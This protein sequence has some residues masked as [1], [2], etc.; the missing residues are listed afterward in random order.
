MTQKP[1]NGSLRSI[2]GK[3]CIFYDGHWIRHYPLPED[4]LAN[5]KH[6]IDSLTRR[7][8]HHTEA[9]I[10][11]PGYRLDEARAAYEQEKVSS[12]KRVNGAMLAGALFNRATDIFTAIVDLE[13]KGVAIGHDNPLMIECEN[14]FREAL[15]LGKQVKHY[16]GEEGIDEL[17]GEPLKA[18]TQPLSQLFESRYRKI[19]QTMEDIDRVTDKLISTFS[20]IEM[21]KSVVPLVINYASASKLQI[22]TMKSDSAFFQVWPAFIAAREALEQFTPDY[23]PDFSDEI[24]RRVERGVKLITIGAALITYLSEARVP[25]PKSTQQFL[26][27]SDAF[28]KSWRRE[29]PPIKAVNET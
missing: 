3:E 18:F 6:L 26:D 7:T 11:T 24:S 17:W 21:F 13:D 8:F 22:E 14:C 5:R 25:M 19:A 9:G 16:S 27:D 4:T 12:R 29:S 15:E 1:D 23:N 10:N 28:L 2:D 20:K